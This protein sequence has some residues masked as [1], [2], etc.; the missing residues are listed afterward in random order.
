VDYVLEWMID[1][2]V[3]LT[4]ANYDLLNWWDSEYPLGPEDTLPDNLL[5]DETDD[6]S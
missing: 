3:P 1:H 5:E 4:R 6:E 2:N